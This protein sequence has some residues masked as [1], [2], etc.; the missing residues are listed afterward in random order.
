MKV[1]SIGKDLIGSSIAA[2]DV[3]ISL[4]EVL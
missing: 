3:R 1:D 2:I 4:V